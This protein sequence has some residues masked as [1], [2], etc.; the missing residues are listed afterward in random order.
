M[1]KGLDH[2]GVV[3]K[4]TENMLKACGE[5]LGLEPAPS[6]VNEQYGIKVTF[7]PV[8][9]SEV[10]FIEPIRPRSALVDLTGNQDEGIH[11]LCFEV[12]DIYEEL[13]ALEAKGVRLLTKEPLPSRTGTVL[14]LDPRD[15]GGMLVELKQK[16]EAGS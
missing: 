2:V 6:T 7:I 11:H 13:K 9:N 1:I 3:V 4:D 10:E 16:P 14:Y 15:T 8:G 5:V 12:D